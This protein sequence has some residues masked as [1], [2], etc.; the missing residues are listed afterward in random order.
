M[1]QQHDNQDIGAGG[2]DSLCI[3]LELAQVEDLYPDQYHHNFLKGTVLSFIYRSVKEGS[4]PPST[5]HTLSV[6]LS[7]SLSCW[8]IHQ[9]VCTNGLPFLCYFSAVSLGPSGTYSSNSPASP[10]SSASLTSPL[11]PFSL[12][13]GSQSSPTKQGSNEVSKFIIAHCPMKMQQNGRGG[14]VPSRGQD[15][16]VTLLFPGLSFHQ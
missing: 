12:V 8:S 1:C 6:G 11:S 16:L 15:A 10:L 5:I 9:L 7:R 4:V 3:S 2:Q 13:S 14:S